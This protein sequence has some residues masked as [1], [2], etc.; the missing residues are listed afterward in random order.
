MRWTGLLTAA[1]WLL[2]G[3]AM[4]QDFDINAFRQ[5][6]K[7]AIAA[8]NGGDFAAARSEVAQARAL[9]P[10][11][12]SVLMLGAQ[13]ESAAGDNPATKAWVDDYLKRGLW[14]DPARYPGLMMVMDDAAKA[15]LAANGADLGS[16][17]TLAEI[18]EA[19]LVESVAIAGDGKLY[20]GTV[21]DGAVNRL[22]K[23]YVIHDLPGGVGGYG[24][25]VDADTAWLATSPGGVAGVSAALRLPEVLQLRLKDGELLQHFGHDDAKGFN[26]LA[27]GKTD[28][29][30]SDSQGGAVYR[31]RG[32]GGAL[33]GLIPAGRLG[34]P[35]GLAES[36][37]GK[38]LIVADYPSGLWR[39]DLATGAASLLAVP[40]TASLTGVDGVVRD[41]DDLIVVQ[42]GVK[43]ARGLRVHMKPDWQAIESVEVL[44]R[45]GQ[46]EE[47]TGGVIDG[48]D[49]VFVARSQWTDFGDDGGV[50]EG[51]AK[52]AII[53]R[54]KLRD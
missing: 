41:G 18:P 40:D 35:Q 23:R 54:L 17:A 29:Y 2:A 53:G 46:L 24:L 25:A 19:V 9:L 52:P 51:G 44:L 5:H 37:D 33:E 10:S 27:L 26:D 50:V 31:L 14:F 22:E 7:A 8:V 21:H 30:T 32:R 16:F 48:G 20:F 34:S 3:S 39:V 49:Y 43:P 47:P 45:G 42:N 4:A 36:S 1:A 11:A 12:P 13:I 6:R 28:L 15:L 38:T